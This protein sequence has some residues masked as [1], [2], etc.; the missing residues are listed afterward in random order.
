VTSARS[1]FWSLPSCC[2]L[3][4]CRTGSVRL[5]LCSVWFTAGE[6][7]LETTDPH[8]IAYFGGKQRQQ[9]RPRSALVASF[10]P[11]MG[12][13][14]LVA[15]SLLSALVPSWAASVPINHG[16]WQL[17]GPSGTAPSQSCDS[18][19]A[20]LN[21]HLLLYGGGD[22]SNGYWVNDQ[23][24]ALDLQTLDTNPR[25]RVV[26]EV[27]ADDVKHRF[28]GGAESSS[29]WCCVVGLQSGRKP[30]MR[31]GSCMVADTRDSDTPRLIVTTGYRYEL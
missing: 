25:W 10:L 28:E 3:W 31:T 8:H 23:V 21:R 30:D 29:H 20:V 12:R 22:G 16:V 13:W 11:Q 9:N 14:L 5:P 4:V 17:I 15:L 18:T 1:S 6:E 2:F 24:Y 19:V 26:G 27:S 7:L